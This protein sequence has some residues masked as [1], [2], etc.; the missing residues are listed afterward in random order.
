MGLTNWFKG[1]LKEEWEA[2]RD[3]ALDFTPI[4]I[5]REAGYIVSKGELPSPIFVNFNETS[6]QRNQI[7]N[8]LE[9]SG[10]TVYKAAV[11]G[12]FLIL[13]VS[14]QDR[15]RALSLLV[16]SGIPVT[17]ETPSKL[18]PLIMD[19]LH[20]AGLVSTEE[21]REM[22]SRRGEY[23]VDSH[24]GGVKLAKQLREQGLKARVKGTLF[25]GFKVETW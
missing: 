24:G 7:T 12:G 16:S 2:T 19:G 1:W 14:N 3:N 15:D 5:V 8:H 11:S 25:T 18:T 17:L 6:L 10:I 9:A 20:A 13:D 22:K 23:P 21:V 4:N